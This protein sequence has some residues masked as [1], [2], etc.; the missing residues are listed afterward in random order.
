MHRSSKLG[1]LILVSVV[2]LGLTSLMIDID[3]Q[4][5]IAFS[6]E[7]DGNKEIY[8][9][10]ADGKNLRRLTNNDFP[11][12][13]PSWSPDGKRIIFVSD[14]NNNIADE[15]PPIMVDGAIIVGD[16]RK[17]PQIYVM[18]ADG[19]NQHRLSNEFVA[20]WDPSWSPDGK[21]I[22]FTSSGAMDVA[23]GHW[24]IYVMDADGGHKKNLSNEG[25]DDYYPAWS[26]DGTR[27]TFVSIRDGRGNQDIYV[28][29][30]DGSDQQR[31]TENPDHEWEPSWSPDGERIAF[32]SSKLPDLMPANSDIYL[33]DADGENPR[34]L[35]RNASRNTHPSWSP[36]G[37]RIAFVSNRDENYE[38]Y[39]MNADG[40][41]Q[42]RRRTRDGSEDTDPTWFD[43]AFAVEV[44]PL[45]VAPADKMFTMWGWLKRVDR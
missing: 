45:A 44:V 1:H 41:R 2:A 43:P 30:A 38:I 5:Q 33:I 32:S 21:R 13:D 29:N 8:V 24:R 6:S 27:I 37:E 9:M 17:R 3:A 36:D 12:T 31:L 10:D 35:T 26:P 15:E 28:M 19:K 25:E 16:M 23:G 7:R 34:K 40:A 42:V 39:V 18:D 14:R 4:A 11:D 22:V 20:E